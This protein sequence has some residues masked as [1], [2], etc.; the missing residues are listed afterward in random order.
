MFS[1]L[2][3]LKK[4]ALLEVLRTNTRNITC[5]VISLFI[6]KG[7]RSLASP[8]ITLYPYPI[9]LNDNFL[10][11]S[12]AVLHDVQALGWHIQ[13]LTIHGIARDFLNITRGC[14][15]INTCYIILLYIIKY[16]PIRYKIIII[17]SFR[18]IQDTTFSI[19][20]HKNRS[21]N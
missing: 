10:H 5:V 17:S 18:N 20:I 14:D 16:T 19:C 12:I 8:N 4:N 1:K 11:T 21:I 13:S 6:Q 9:L 15:I 7:M 2:P 3:N